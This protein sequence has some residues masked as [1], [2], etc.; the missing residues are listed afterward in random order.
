MTNGRMWMAAAGGALVTLLGC[1]DDRGTGATTELAAELSLEMRDT[2]RT[3]LVVGTDGES[4]TLRLTPSRSFGVLPAG[5]TIVGDGRI[6]RFPEA[7]MTLYSAKLSAPAEPAGPCRDQPISL[8]LSLQRQGSNATV[9]G[10]LTAYCGANR[11]Y[12]VPPR[13]LRVAGELGP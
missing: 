13:V 4:F 11:W 2:L 8:A 12:G 5:S 3:R 1:V 10:G 6:E 7:N 9:I